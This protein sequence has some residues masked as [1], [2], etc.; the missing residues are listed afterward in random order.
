MLIDTRYIFSSAVDGD[1]FTTKNINAPGVLNLDGILVNEKKQVSYINKRYIGRTIKI[2]ASSDL[3]SSE[4][5]I[6]GTQN[7]V[8]INETIQG[9]TA[10]NEMVSLN[11][12][13]TIE[14]IELN[15]DQ[16]ETAD[17]LTISSGDLGIVAI[18]VNL[19]TSAN[20]IN[21]LLSVMDVYIT[22]INTVAKASIYLSVDQILDNGMP[23]LH[24]MNQYNTVPG[25]NP[26]YGILKTIDEDDSTLVSQA[27]NTM[28]KSII[29]K[30][31]INTDSAESRIIQYTQL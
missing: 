28:Y 13:D 6:F 17:D 30:I 15:L 9:L 10:G 23:I 26:N 19:K 4:F 20:T 31:D 2:T 25:W 18:P 12:F 14:F 22:G 21:G 16:F 24:Q 7:N 1:I 29:V 5:I 11:A 27:I 8:I 3:D